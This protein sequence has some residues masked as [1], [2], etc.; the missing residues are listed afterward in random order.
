M[1]T[2]H[3]IVSFAR[4]WRQFCDCSPYQL[5]CCC[6]FSFQYLLHYLVSV[7]NLLNRHAWSRTPIAETAWALLKDS[8]HGSVCV[9][10]PPQHLAISVLYL[11]IQSYGMEM[12][13]GE[14]EWWQV[15]T[16]W[17]CACCCSHD[18][19]ALVSKVSVS[20]YLFLFLL[21]ACL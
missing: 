20:K 3:E 15:S 5:I 4:I 18:C 13:S 12:P 2:C 7:R 9:R 11:A 17:L 10:H 14:L 21:F 6:C 16:V 8:Y 19:E 1:K